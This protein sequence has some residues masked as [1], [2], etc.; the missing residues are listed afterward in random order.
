LVLVALGFP[1]ADAIAALLV[2]VWVGILAIRLGKKNVD[3][4]LDRVPDDY[5]EEVR[6]TVLGT[7]G[8]LSIEKLRMRRSGSFLFADLR[9]SMD[10]T[11]PFERA[12][13]LALELEERLAKEFPGLDAVVHTDPAAAPDEALDGGILSFLRTLGFQAHHLTFHELDQRFFA[14]LHLEVD[15]ALPLKEAHNLASHLEKEILAHFPAVASV[16]IH[17]EEGSN[18]NTKELSDEEL[19]SNIINEISSLS[20]TIIGPNRCHRITVKRSAGA[21]SA[22]LHCLFPESL[23]VREVHQKTTHLEEELRRSIPE[24]GRVLIHAEPIK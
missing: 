6:K 9:V 14:E 17:I 2:A 16:Q 13:S 23:S 21:L 7:R 22:S 12:H 4:L 1:T 10:R 15:G 11:L 20:E 3:I 5:Y 18:L 19:H 24:L 8:V